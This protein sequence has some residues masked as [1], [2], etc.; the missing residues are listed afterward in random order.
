V[1]IPLA[2]AVVLGCALIG[3]WAAWRALR[4]RP[5]ILRQLVAGGVVEALLLVQAVVA[6]VATATGRPPA[7]P[8]TWWG[9]L[10]T[11]LLVLPFA[12]AWAFAE[13]SRWSSVVLLVAAVTVA[14]L[15]YRM[16]QVW[17][18]T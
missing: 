13:R 2:G 7:D 1:W 10:V 11:T 3:V 8:V 15:Q 16:V 14:F 18:G 12:A 4:D 9:Y 5:V 6:A 17:S